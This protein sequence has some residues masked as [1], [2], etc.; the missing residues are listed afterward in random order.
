[1][2]YVFPNIRTD[3]GVVYW[4]IL[5]NIP[6]LHRIGVI[7]CIVS[8]LIASFFFWSQCLC[9]KISCIRVVNIFSLKASSSVE[10]DDLIYSFIAFIISFLMLYVVFSYI[11]VI[12]ISLLLLFF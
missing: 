1:M 6:C 8:L 4:M 12:S 9:F 3:F 7:R 11:L 10:F 5:S 2:R